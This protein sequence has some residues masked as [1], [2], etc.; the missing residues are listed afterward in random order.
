MVN[1]Y[2]TKLCLRIQESFLKERHELSLE[3]E[4]EDTKL[5]EKGRLF[6]AEG[7][8]WAEAEGCET[9]E[10]APISDACLRL[11]VNSY[12]HPAAW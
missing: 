11:P 2:F 6:R 4:K 5:G 9:A 12:H 10:A 8:T 3:K 7:E 1:N